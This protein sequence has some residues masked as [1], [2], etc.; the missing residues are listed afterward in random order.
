MILTRQVWGVRGLP[1]A[2][3][4]PLRIMHQARFP[5]HITL[6]YPFLSS[7]TRSRPGD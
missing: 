4:L 7:H 2:P 3:H 1:H 5:Y 6:T